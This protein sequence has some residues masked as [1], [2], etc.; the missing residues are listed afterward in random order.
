MFDK[1]S[2]NRIK[3]NID[4]VDIIR[5]SVPTLKSAGR[6]FKALSP[7]TNEKTPSFVVSREKQFFKDFS[8]GKGG[9]V[10]KFVQEFHNMNFNEAIEFLAQKAG[11]DLVKNENLKNQYDYIDEL[12]KSMS[13][14]SEYYHKNLLQNSNKADKYLYDRGINQNSIIDFQLGYA[15]DSWNDL[16]KYLTSN[17]FENDLLTEAGLVKNKNNK[18]YDAYRDRL[19]FPIRD[20]LGRTIGLG[21]RIFEKSEKSAKYINSPQNKIYDKSKVLYGLFEA[22]REINNQDYAILVEGYFDVISLHQEGIKNVIAS[23]GTA[24]STYQLKIISRHTKNLYIIY[25]SDKAGQSAANKV[26]DLALE[27]GMNVKLVNLP[28]GEDPDSIIKN[29]GRNTFNKYL[30]D[31]ID[32]VKFRINSFGDYSNPVK[33]AELLRGLVN[34]I[35]KIPDRLQHDIYINKIAQYLNLSEFQVSNIYQ[36][37]LKSEKSDFKSTSF[38]IKTNNT[39][40]LENINSKDEFINKIQELNS[41]E[42]VLLNYL[43]DNFQEL[44]EIIDEFELSEDIFIT[45]LALEIYKVLI[46]CESDSFLDYVENNKDLKPELKEIITG[47]P[48]YNEEVNST[49]AEYRK[50]N[51]K[52]NKNSIHQTIISLKIN[53]LLSEDD[54]LDESDD[55][56]DLLVKKAE[57]QKQI[58]EL[59]NQRAE[60]VHE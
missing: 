30:R 6:D 10:I 20:D 19:I 15:L 28:D 16:H 13:L 26:M 29:Y 21:G 57:I 34:S 32:F 22:K 27:E 31:A 41:A 8:S 25:D 52:L 40:D 53:K 58:N 7:F 55:D 43:I 1:E 51:S 23:S 2:V 37:K 45:K 4:I 44:E 39:Q 17:G 54:S 48:F 59:E 12:R 9:D 11:I 36:E 42:I 46:N 60:L 14:A 56:D 50:L 24:L 5:E 49:L 47:L 38:K 3:E 35:K 33:E 18:V